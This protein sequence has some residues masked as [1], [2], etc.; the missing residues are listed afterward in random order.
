MLLTPSTFPM[1][2]LPLIT[3]FTF[4]PDVGKRG[5]ESNSARAAY[6]ALSYADAG[7]IIAILLQS[8]MGHYSM[9]G[10]P[11]SI[12]SPESLYPENYF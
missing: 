1:I 9:T 10:E 2:P 3:A 11:T 12:Y 8:I 4:A 5:P 7:R 6:G